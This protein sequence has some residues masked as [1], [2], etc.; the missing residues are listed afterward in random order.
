MAE[1]RK[2]KKSKQAMPVCAGSLHVEGEAKEYSQSALKL[3]HC[4][5]DPPYYYKAAY[6]EAERVLEDLKK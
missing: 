2:L 1:K 6:E 4:D 5:D 3:A